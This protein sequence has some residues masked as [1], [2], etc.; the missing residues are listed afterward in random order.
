M[1]VREA[2]EYD[3]PA[4]L[5]LYDQLHNLATAQKPTPQ[6]KA[7][8]RRILQDE[9]QHVLVAEDG[10][11]VVS[12]CVLVVVPN[13]THGQRP[14]AFIENVVTHAAHRRR[15]YASAV[16]SHATQIAR[17]QN[18][19]KIMLLTGRKN[20]QTLQ[21]YEKAGFNR[22]DKTGFVQWLDL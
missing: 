10:G 21:F 1:V 2:E 13:L 3:L 7:L 8:W 12:S 19:Y 11:V 4:L 20:P 5:F 16:L 15:G 22:A 17:E 6:T 18:C 14:Y 9:N